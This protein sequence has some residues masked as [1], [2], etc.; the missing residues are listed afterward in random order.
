MQQTEI[1]VNGTMN[2]TSSVE[3]DVPV[4]ANGA[5]SEENGAVTR[6]L[7]AP[8]A[9]N[10]VPPKAVV[11]TEVENNNLTVTSKQQLKVSREEERSRTR[12][13]SSGKD[14]HKVKHKLGAPLH[15]F[16]L[17]RKKKKPPLNRR[18]KRSYHLHPPKRNQ[19]ETT[20]D[21]D[22]ETDDSDDESETRAG[23]KMFKFNIK[24]MQ[25]FKWDKVFKNGPSKICGR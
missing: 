12:V 11:V 13:V 22:D 8:P 7:E 5:T 16:L 20:T 4:A 6:E 23:N 1:D 24:D 10:N 25:P 21:F 17:F 2:E 18:S 14:H 9:E 19:G 3:N 15:D